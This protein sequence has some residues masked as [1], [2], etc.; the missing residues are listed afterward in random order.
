MKRVLR[1]LFGLKTKILLPLGIVCLV[2]LY[3]VYTSISAMYREERE[4]AYVAK[5]QALLLS[6]ES[7]REYAATQYN[8]DLFRNDIKSKD[9]LL[10]TVPVFAAMQVAKLKAK[11]LGMEIRVPKF[12]P[13]NPDNQ[14]DGFEA[15][16]LHKLESGTLSEY[17]E[18]DTASDKLRYFRPVKLSKEC[19]NCHGDPANSMSLWGNNEGLDPTG[20]RM[21]N[22]KEGEVHGAFEVLMPMAPVRAAAKAGADKIA[23]TLLYLLGAL[24]VVGLGIAY[25]VMRPVKK[26]MKANA[27]VSNGDLSARVD[28]GSYDELGS[29][30]ESFNQMVENIQ[31]AQKTSQEQNAYLSDAVSTIVLAMDRFSHGKDH[32]H[33]QADGTDDI[34]RLKRGFN[35][36]ITTIQESHSKNEA[37]RLYLAESVNEVLGAMQEFSQGNLDTQLEVTSDDEIGQLKT[38]FNSVVLTMRSIVK[39]VLGSVEASTEAS[40]HISMSTEEMAAGAHE[41]T[42]QTTD[43]ASAVEEMTKTIIENSENARSTAEMALRA[44][45]TAEAG[46]RV[47]QGTVDGMQRIAEVVR[48]SASTIDALGRSS[49][50]IGEIILVIN[51]IADQTNLLALNAAIEAARAGEQGR[52]FAV[53]ADE[54]RK[55]AERTTSATTEISSMIQS[56]QRDT[57]SAVHSINEGTREVN[58]GIEMTDQAGTS[59]NEIADAVRNVAE[60]VSQI[61]LA[62]AEQSNASET[63]SRSIQGISDVASQT[64]QGTEQI[65]RAADDLHALTE[66]LHDAVRIF[67]LSTDERRATHK[68]RSATDHSLQSS[69]STVPRKSRSIV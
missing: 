52:G 16:V 48:S 69:S 40:R 62:N 3:Q 10:Y 60:M 57:S 8:K 27:K 42:L 56:I 67:S 65:A 7:A 41:Q 36:M 31:T 17:Y 34:A 24:L 38:G 29:L 15:A 55:L 14:P 37:Q 53:V 58:A 19:L 59:F 21:E 61:A 22:W 5:A 30:G 54:V 66:R 18:V 64:A 32:I 51:D 33:I 4:Q 35:E 46:V 45:E 68:V 9:D 2:G 28:A 47:L 12:Q 6:A 49:T 26:L 63:I 43:V 39:N 13:R 23:Q 50:Q 44:R 20:A 11:T 25:M 1:R